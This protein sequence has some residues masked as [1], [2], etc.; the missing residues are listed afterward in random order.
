MKQIYIEE[1]L[2]MTNYLMHIRIH[3]YAKNPL[4]FYFYITML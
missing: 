3:K 1:I 4:Q 2:A